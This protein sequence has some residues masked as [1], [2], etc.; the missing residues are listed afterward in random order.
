ML[1]PTLF[2]PLGAIAGATSGERNLGF[3]LKAA[4]SGHCDGTAFFVIE[5]G[6][7]TLHFWLRVTSP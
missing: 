1:K 2:L 7:S 4:Y 5:A 3:L 6:N